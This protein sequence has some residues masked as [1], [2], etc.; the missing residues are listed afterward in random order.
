[1]DLQE[2]GC[3]YVDW[4]EV[5]ENRDKCLALV[6]RVMDIRLLRNFLTR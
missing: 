5:A 4:I 2:I 6:K 1:M 3:G